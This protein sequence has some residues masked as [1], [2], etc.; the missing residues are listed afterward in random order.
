M[1]EEDVLNVLLSAYREAVEDVARY[2]GNRIEEIYQESISQFY[3]KY[4]PSSYS[5]KE[6][7]RQ[8]SSGYGKSK[9]YKGTRGDLVFRAGIKVAASNIKGVYQSNAKYPY[10]TNEWIFN[11]AYYEGIHGF[12]AQDVAIH[13]RAA[14]LSKQHP[15]KDFDAL[16]LWNPEIIPPVMSPPP[17]EI[18]EKKFKAITT[19][20]SL[21]D[22]FTKA[23]NK[24]VNQLS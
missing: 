4:S 20:K 15:S 6:F 23:F 3:K 11:R 8:A 2:T 7:L 13:N 22:R 18:M 19:H 9:H 16:H 12:S 1:F 21:S 10:I 17:A 14:E 5:R 24:R